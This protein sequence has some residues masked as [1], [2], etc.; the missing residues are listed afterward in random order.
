M[1]IVT[2]T[3]IRNFLEGYG[4]TA[5]VLSDPWI[6]DCRDNVVVPHIEDITGMSFSG[7]QEITEYYSGNGTS[8]LILNRK[9]IVEVTNFTYIGA[10]TNYNLLGVI[11]LIDAEGMLKA[12]TDY[13]EGIY[14]PIFRKGNKNI[15]ITY[16]YGTSDYSAVVNNAI[17]RLVA[18]Q[19]LSLLGNRTGGGDLSVQAHGRSYGSH[20]K[21]T[22]IM[23]Q[24]AHTAY[25]LLKP[26]M[27]G[28]VGS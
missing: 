10:V 15:R 20:G 22:N 9:P 3:E 1:P 4:I 17:K 18:V 8:V 12:K 28:V 6:K 26:W 21:Y 19:I 27:T 25:Q 11:E 13:S 24:L 16:K 14:G 23:K 2:E 7:I 5:T